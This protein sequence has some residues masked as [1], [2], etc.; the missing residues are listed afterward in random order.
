MFFFF[1]FKGTEEQWV[2]H[3]R[4]GGRGKRVRGKR[5]GTL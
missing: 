2:I 1:F 5:T 4:C 3:S